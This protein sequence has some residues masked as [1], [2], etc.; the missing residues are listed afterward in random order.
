MKAQELRVGNLINVFRHPED[1]TMTAMKAM[2]IALVDGVYWTELEDGFMVNIEDGISPIP[3]TEDCLLKFGFENKGDGIY[4]KQQ[5]CCNWGHRVSISEMGIVFSH[6]FMNQWSE[7]TSLDHIHQVQ[8]L[9][10]AL[11]GEELQPTK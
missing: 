6:G 3:I 7:L 2:D 1:K 9:I 11:T 10:F 4:Y 5:D 8:N